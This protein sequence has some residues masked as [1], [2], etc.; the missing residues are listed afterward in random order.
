M[1][2]VAEMMAGVCLGVANEKVAADRSDFYAQLEGA[3][4]FF[5]QARV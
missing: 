3:I 4:R 5:K 1:A 2:D